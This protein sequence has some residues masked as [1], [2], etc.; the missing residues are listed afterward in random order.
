M[1]S[2]GEQFS[3]PVFITK[4]IVFSWKHLIKTWMFD[5]NFYRSKRFICWSSGTVLHKYDLATSDS[6]FLLYINLTVESTFR[7]S[8][9]SKTS[10]FIFKITNTWMILLKLRTRAGLSVFFSNLRGILKIFDF[11]LI[12]VYTLQ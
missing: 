10:L 9:K 2:V 5:K 12:L 6:I 8:W 4:S 1:F 7:G 3:H 11:W